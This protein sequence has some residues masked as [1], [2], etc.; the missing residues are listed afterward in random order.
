MKHQ[1][2]SKRGVPRVG[3]ICQHGIDLEPQGHLLVTSG[4]MASIVEV[5]VMKSITTSVFN[6]N[7]GHLELLTSK[8][9]RTMGFYKTC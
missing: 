9:F 5:K 1:I 3:T 8:H 7:D 4:S 6:P 2:K